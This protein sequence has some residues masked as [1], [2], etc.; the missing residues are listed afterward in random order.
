M[1]RRFDIGYL[2]ENP[3]MRRTA[4]AVGFNV[5]RRAGRIKVSKGRKSERQMRNLPLPADP[6]AA[7]LSRQTFCRVAA[8]IYRHR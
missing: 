2:S 1:I 7:N 3:L 8:T 6:G 4:S 5:R